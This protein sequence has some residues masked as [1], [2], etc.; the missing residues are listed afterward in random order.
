MDKSWIMMNE[1]NIFTDDPLE[2]VFQVYA[3]V[4]FSWKA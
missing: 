2:V 3:M 1:W 4:M